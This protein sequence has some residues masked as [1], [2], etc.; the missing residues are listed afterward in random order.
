MSDY[1]EGFFRWMET[2]EGQCIWTDFERK[3]LQMA[4]VRKRYSAMAIAQ[5]IRWETSL[6]DGSEFK[7][8]NNWIPGLARVWV[9]KHG[10]RHP[11]F[12]QLRDSLGY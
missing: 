3:A 7:L 12:F 4:K 5:V 2:V 1:P 6:Q 8:N 9:K 11:K 10:H